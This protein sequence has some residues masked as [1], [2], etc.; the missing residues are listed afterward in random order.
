MCAELVC[1]NKLQCGEV[2]R[3]V[4]VLIIV[5]LSWIINNR[6]SETTIMLSANNF[7]EKFF[8]G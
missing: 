6:D 8:F 1:W 5:M 3:Y 4:T 2:T 7:N